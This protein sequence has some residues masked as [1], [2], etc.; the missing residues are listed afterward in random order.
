MSAKMLSERGEEKAIKRFLRRSGSREYFKDGG[1]TDN[2]EEANN[3][4]DAVEVAEICA[5]YGLTD[6]ELALRFEAGAG[7]VFCTAIR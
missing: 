6:V 4:S 2:P 1:W 3:F 5:R 7:D